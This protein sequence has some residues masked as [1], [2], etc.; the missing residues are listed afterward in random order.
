MLKQVKIVGLNSKKKIALVKIWDYILRTLTSCGDL[1]TPQKTG[2]INQH[3]LTTLHQT[4]LYCCGKPISCAD[5]EYE[6]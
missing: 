5:V 6:Q 2:L 3:P 1:N 4:L